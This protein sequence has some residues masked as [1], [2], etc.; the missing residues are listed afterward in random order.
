MAV[1]T[2]RSASWA[3]ESREIQEHPRGR[4]PPFAPVGRCSQVVDVSGDIL[5]GDAST[6]GLADEPDR[7]LGDLVPVPT[8]IP[9]DY[10]AW[11]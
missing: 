10:A 9:A 11:S 3:H 8:V 5:A 4:R 7:G 2:V 6:L 1:R